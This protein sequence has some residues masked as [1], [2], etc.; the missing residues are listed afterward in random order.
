MEQSLMY[1]TWALV[2]VTLLL[3]GVTFWMARKQVDLLREQTKD[4]RANLQLQNH[5]TFAARFDSRELQSDR[6]LL[7]QRLLEGAPHDKISENVLDFFE[8]LGLFLRRGYLDEEL[9]WDTFGFYAVRWWAACKDYI[10][11]ERKRQN[12]E[13]LF[14]DFENLVRT[15]RTLDAKSGLAEPTAAEVKAFLE[16]EFRLGD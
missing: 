1:G 6:K 15:L 12:D 10:L 16:G 11:E 9:E 4:A 14:T 2:G 3:V 5:L 8:D 13:T 7:A